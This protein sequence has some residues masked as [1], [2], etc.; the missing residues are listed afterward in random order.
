[1][2]SKRKEKQQQEQQEDSSSSSPPPHPLQLLSKSAHPAWV[3]KRRSGVERRIENGTLHSSMK[4]RRRRVALVEN[5]NWTFPD[6]P[7]AFREKF[8]GRV[9][10]GSKEHDAIARNLFANK[11]PHLRS[12]A[13]CVFF[14]RYTPVKQSSRSNEPYVRR[15]PTAFVEKGE[16]ALQ[17]IQKL[18]EGGDGSSSDGGDE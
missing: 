2:P 7:P 16:L 18:R 11:S 4:T 9:R 1:M 17:K 10:W 6:E 3:D 14:P 13:F 15:K 12:K 5:P 8:G